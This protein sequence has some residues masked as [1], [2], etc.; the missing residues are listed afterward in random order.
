MLSV[1]CLQ[2][3]DTLALNLQN[4]WVFPHCLAFAKEAAASS[5]C[6]IRAAGCTVLVVCAEGC[7]DACTSHL[8]EV[9]QVQATPS[10]LTALVPN[11]TS[12]IVTL[13]KSVLMKGNVMTVAIIYHGVMA[14]LAHH[15]NDSR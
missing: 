3:I 4:K 9:L 1:V 7:C 14:F 11:T 6:N 2:A 15:G 12:V 8:P 10:T 13:V 5:D